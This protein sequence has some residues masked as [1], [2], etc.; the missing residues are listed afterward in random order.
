MLEDFVNEGG[1]LYCGS[2]A[3]KIIPFI[4]KKI[5][6]CRATDCKLIYICDSHDKDDKEFSMFKPHCVEGTKAA[7]VIDELKPEKKDIVLKK[8]R[9]SGFYGTELDRILEEMGPEVVEVVGVCT[10]ICVMDTVGGLRN[11]D[12]RVKVYKDGVADFD[13]DAHNFSLERM[14]EIYGAEVV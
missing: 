2:D 9:Y 13:K 14:K 3:E 5:D 4:K 6:E 8:K 12:Y 10:S 1:V 11:R 7:E